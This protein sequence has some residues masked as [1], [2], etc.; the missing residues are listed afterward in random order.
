[1]HVHD[2]GLVAQRHVMVENHLLPY[3]GDLAEVGER[4]VGCLQRIFDY[5]RVKKIA[6]KS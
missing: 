3:D 5:V 2:D 4:F 1:L 6:A